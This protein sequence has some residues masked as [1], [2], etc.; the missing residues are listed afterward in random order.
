[1]LLHNTGYWWCNS[2]FESSSDSP[3]LEIDLRSYPDLIFGTS[4]MYL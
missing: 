2:L 3:D 1:M 4:L